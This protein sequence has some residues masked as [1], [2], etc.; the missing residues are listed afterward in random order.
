MSS[1]SSAYELDDQPSIPPQLIVFQE[2]R[3]QVQPQVN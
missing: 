3:K 1:S 2:E